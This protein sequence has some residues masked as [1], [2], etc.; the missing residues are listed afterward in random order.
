MSDDNPLVMYLVVRE[1]LLPLMSVGKIGGQCGHAVQYAM[2][3]FYEAHRGTFTVAQRET[4]AQWMSEGHTKVTLRASDKEFERVKKGLTC[5][6]VKDLGRT[7]V[8]ASHSG[9]VINQRRARVAA[10]LSTVCAATRTSAGAR[11]RSC[12]TQRW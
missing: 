5:F 3:A 9:A 11:V 1:S 4:F 12:P 7:E 2:T 6:V 8:P 10:I